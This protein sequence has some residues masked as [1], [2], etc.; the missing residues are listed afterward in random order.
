MKVVRMISPCNL[1]PPTYETWVRSV[2]NYIN[3]LPGD[4][5]HIVIDTY[6]A[7]LD[8]SQPT[9]V[10]YKTSGQR[11]FISDLSQKL[12]IT[13]DAWNDFLSNDQNKHDITNLM[14]KYILDGLYLFNR[15]VYVTNGEK[16]ILVQAGSLID[17]SDLHSKHKEADPRLALHAIY[18]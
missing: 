14:I 12:P 18:A 7:A 2:Y 11:I 13:Q 5:L 15:P 16:C 17:V 6:P 1:K 8:L 10:R 4:V 3:I 9:K